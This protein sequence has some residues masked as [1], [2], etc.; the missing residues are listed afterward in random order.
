MIHILIFWGRLVIKFKNLLA[1]ETVVNAINYKKN[2]NRL[3]IK[4]ML[5]FL[6][7]SNPRIVSELERANPFIEGSKDFVNSLNSD[8]T[9][10]SS[11][12]DDSK[13]IRI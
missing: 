3:L 11:T 4:M 2:V 8:N 12:S 1:T 9:G 7:S 5:F 13:F 6:Q 10:P